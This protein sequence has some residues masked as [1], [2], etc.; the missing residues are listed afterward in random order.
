MIQAVIA[1]ELVHH[2][3]PT[4]SVDVRLVLPHRL[5][6][7]LQ[8]SHLYEHS[9]THAGLWKGFITSAAYPGF[10]KGGQNFRSEPRSP[11]KWFPP[12]VR[13]CGIYWM[14]RCEQRIV[15][16]IDRKYILSMVPKIRIYATLPAQEICLQTNLTKAHKQKQKRNNSQPWRGSNP[17]PTTN[18]WQAGCG[19]KAWK[20]VHSDFSWR[21]DTQNHH[22]KPPKFKSSIN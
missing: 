19:C 18:H 15:Q 2:D 12:C 3:Q 4:P 10:P 17:S 7:L 6:A 16:T 21:Q 22:N 13:H 5:N 11:E 14:W 20:T 1:L 9:C 8:H